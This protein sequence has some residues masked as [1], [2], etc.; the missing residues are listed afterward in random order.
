MLPEGRLNS[1]VVDYL[2]QNNLAE[3]LKLAETLLAEEAYR[4]TPSYTCLWLCECA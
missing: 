3:L 2:S 1:V 4:L